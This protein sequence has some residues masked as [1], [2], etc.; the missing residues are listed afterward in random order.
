MRALA[1]SASS[2]SKTGEPKPLGQRRTTQVTTP[3]QESPRFLTSSIAAFKHNM[4]IT[5]HAQHVTAPLETIDMH[6][7]MLRMQKV[8][9]GERMQTDSQVSPRLRAA[10][11][12]TDA[13]M[14]LLPVSTA[15]GLQAI[16]YAYIHT[17]QYQIL[18]TVPNQSQSSRCKTVDACPN[19]IIL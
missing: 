1:S 17:A 14:V 18:C 11:C 13:S 2:L 12:R 7:L 19:S 15:P 5:L 6:I 8:P 10:W 16:A 9:R 3:P 4:C